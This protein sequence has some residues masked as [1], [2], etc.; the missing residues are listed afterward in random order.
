MLSAEPDTNPDL[1]S[2]YSSYHASIGLTLPSADRQSSRRPARL[3]SAPKGR[4][5]WATMLATIHEL[6][7]PPDPMRNPPDRSGRPRSDG[8]PFRPR[9]TDWGNAGTFTVTV[10]EELPNS[11]FA[12]RWHDPTLCN[13]EEQIWAPCLARTT[14]RCALSGEHINKGDP[15]YR[16]RVRGRFIPL[17][18]DEAILASELIKANTRD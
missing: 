17:N 16:P 2:D 6:A 15:V 5:V 8:G 11:L 10:V 3:T 1:L 13:Y 12:L 14:G 18:R 4:D 7:S 9:M